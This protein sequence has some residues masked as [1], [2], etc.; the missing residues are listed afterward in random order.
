M[1]H[2]STALLLCRPPAGSAPA[3]H[4][5]GVHTCSAGARSNGLHFSSLCSSRASARAH[6]M[7]KHS[8]PAAHSC[9]FHIASRQ[10]ND[11]GVL[12]HR[13]PRSWTPCCATLLCM[14]KRGWTCV[15]RAAGDS[16]C[17]ARS[18]PFTAYAGRP[19]ARTALVDT[20]GLSLALPGFPAFAFLAASRFFFASETIAPPQPPPAPQGVP[21]R[22]RSQA[23]LVWLRSML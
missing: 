8:C 3:P 19:L 21:Q 2:Q 5:A 17:A 4:G 15:A 13:A 16:S 23:L 9:G 14:L 12:T 6:W 1:L 18:H 11:R 7:F 22:R 20:A 10:T